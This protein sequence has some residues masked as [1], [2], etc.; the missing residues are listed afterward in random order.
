MELYDGVSDVNWFYLGKKTREEMDGDSRFPQDARS[1]LFDDGAGRVYRWRYLNMMCDEFGVAKT[2]DAQA[3]FD[4]VVA[5]MQDP[6]PTTEQKV[7]EIE[8][9]MNALTSAF[10][11]TE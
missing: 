9:E 8:N 4:S 10:E 5:A 1:V 6:K 2:D 11:V 3:D 7:A